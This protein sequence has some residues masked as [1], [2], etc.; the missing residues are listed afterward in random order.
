[1]DLL[2]VDEV[3]IYK[4]IDLQCGYR[5]LR[6]QVRARYNDGVLIMVGKVLALPETVALF[7]SSIVAQHKLWRLGVLICR[8]WPRTPVIGPALSSQRFDQN[9]AS[10]VC[11]ACST[12]IGGKKQARG[13]LGKSFM[14]A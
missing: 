12:R 8:T 11:T 9:K 1:M 7:V 4:T 6:A 13:V 3:L 5:R 2:V 14:S 10:S